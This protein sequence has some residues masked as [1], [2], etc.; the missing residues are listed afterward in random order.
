MAS[1]ICKC[2]EVLSNR[3][4]PNDIQLHIFTDKEW[5]EIIAK[6]QIETVEL[7]ISEVDIWRCPSD[8]FHEGEGM[9][10]DSYKY[11]LERLNWGDDYSLQNDGLGF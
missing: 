4:S 3:E 7:L 6:G 1:M 11:F 10:I 8:V 5:E 2:G 9:D